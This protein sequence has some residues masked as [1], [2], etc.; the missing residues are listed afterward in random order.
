MF[1][2]INTEILGKIVD[3]DVGL[4]IT[5]ASQQHKLIQPIRNVVRHYLIE[6]LVVLNSCFR[7]YTLNYWVTSLTMMWDY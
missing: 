1:Q 4:L 7:K 5:F 6:V 3:C 2:A